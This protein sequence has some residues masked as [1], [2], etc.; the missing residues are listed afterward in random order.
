MYKLQFSF[1]E[2]LTKS[3]ILQSIL[4]YTKVTR[5]YFSESRTNVIIEPGSQGT[6]CKPILTVQTKAQLIHA[7]IKNPE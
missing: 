5:S 6:F 7:R 3:H 4:P 2:F 1:E